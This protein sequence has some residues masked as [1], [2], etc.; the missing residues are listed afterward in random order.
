ML[1]HIVWISF[2]AIETNKKKIK[3]KTKKEQKY[4]QICNKLRII[5]HEMIR[6]FMHPIILVNNSITLNYYKTK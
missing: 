2:Q 4:I 5:S 3:N 1:C 6:M